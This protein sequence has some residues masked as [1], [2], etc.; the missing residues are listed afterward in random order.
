MSGPRTLRLAQWLVSAAERLM[1]PVRKEWARAMAAE[2][3]YCGGGAG[4]LAFAAGC[5][6]VAI[7]ERV[8]ASIGALS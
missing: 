8:A 1:P 6:G 5:L 4:V 2:L 7:R 3:A